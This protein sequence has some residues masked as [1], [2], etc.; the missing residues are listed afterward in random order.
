MKHWNMEKK[1]ACLLS[2]FF[3]AGLIPI[4]LLARYNYPCADDFGYSAYTVSS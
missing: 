3:L 4:F 1:A 2:V